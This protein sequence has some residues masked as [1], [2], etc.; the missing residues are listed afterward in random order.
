MRKLILSMHMSLD[1]FVE[2]LNKDMSWMKPDT[3]DQWDDLFTM[4]SNVDLFLLG[5]GMW[6]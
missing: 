1:G 2:G 4:L 6:Q 5:G 3:D